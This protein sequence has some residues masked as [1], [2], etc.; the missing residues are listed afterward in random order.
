MTLPWDYNPII[1]PRMDRGWN[2]EAMLGVRI[3]LVRMRLWRCLSRAILSSLTNDPSGCIRE[4]N[5]RGPSASV[6]SFDVTSQLT[7][8]D[9]PGSSN[10]GYR[11]LSG[12]DDIAL[13]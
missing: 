13:E 4:T 6:V 7:A 10:F 8:V 2:D 1:S 9:F 11:T 3:R 5:C 12:D